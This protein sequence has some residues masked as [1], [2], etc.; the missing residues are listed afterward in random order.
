MELNAVSVRPV[1]SQRPNIASWLF[2]RKLR[3]PVPDNIWIK[4]L[5]IYIDKLRTNDCQH[6]LDRITHNDRIADRA[7]LLRHD[8]LWRNDHHV[9]D[10]DNA[11]VPA[12]MQVRLESKHSRLV[13]A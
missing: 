6:D 9:N 7:I 13:P 2:D 12:P 5:R 10:H 4:R 3:M 1:E 8:L 11:A